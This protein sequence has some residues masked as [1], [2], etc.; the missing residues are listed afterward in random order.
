MSETA[1]HDTDVTTHDPDSAWLAAYAL[2]LAYSSN[3]Q[4]EQLELLL[5]AADGDP[6]LL[7]HAHQRLATT[8]VA[9][10]PLRERAQRLLDRARTVQG[11]GTG[12]DHP[13]VAD[14][15]SAWS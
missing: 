7:D 11:A 9:D 2:G 15:A 14:P 5:D 6:E 1:T 10:P 8:E 12:Q 4:Q 13:Q 3:G